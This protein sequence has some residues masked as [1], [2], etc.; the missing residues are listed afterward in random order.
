MRICRLLGHKFRPRYHER[1]SGPEWLVAAM[2]Q[3]ANYDISQPGGIVQDHT[4]TYL[5]DVC[6]RCGSTTEE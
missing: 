3:Q 4:K 2:K 1:W 6:V 5:Y